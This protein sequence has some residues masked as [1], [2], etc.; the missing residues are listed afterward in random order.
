MVEV[1]NSSVTSNIMRHVVTVLDGPVKVVLIALLIISLVMVGGLI[2]EYF[3]RKYINVK[4]V[5]V[6]D[7]I[8]KGVNDPATIIKNSSLLLDQKRLLLELTVHRALS[9]EMKENFAASLIDNYNQNLDFTIRKSDLIIKLGPTFGLLGTLI[10]LG[11]GI[12]AL[13]SGDTMTLSNSLLAA[14]DTTVI[15]LVSASIC[16]I[17]SLIRRRWYSKDRVMLTLIME[18]VL[19]SE[20]KNGGK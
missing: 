13:A 2:A 8:K 20:K 5:S 18:A 11:P 4:A 12:I 14:F 15:G 1:T 9:P 19:E 10:P 6:I 7:A 17:I 16:T 3:Q